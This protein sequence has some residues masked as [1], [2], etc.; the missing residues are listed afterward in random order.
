MICHTQLMQYSL[1]ASKRTRTLPPDGDREEC[2]IYQ[3]KQI[4]GTRTLPPDGDREE[5]VVYQV[6]KTLHD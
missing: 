1:Q 2:V 5:R 3:S 4:K 6:K